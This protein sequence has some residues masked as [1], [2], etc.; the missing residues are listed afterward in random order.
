MKARSWISLGVL[1]SV[2]AAGAFWYARQPPVVTTVSAARGEAAEVVYANGVVEP[3]NW[4]RVTTLVRERLV[5][6]CDCEGESVVAGQVLA[7][8][9]DTEAQTALIELLERRRFAEDEFRRLNDLAARQTAGQTE[10]D[11][12]RTE[13]S[14]LE[15][16]VAGQRARLE[17]YVI[18]AP[19]DGVV[20]RRDAEVGEIAEPGAALFWVGQPRPLVVIADV[21]E[22]DIPRIT[23]GQR[24]LLRS[25]AFIELNLAAVVDNV[26]PKGDPVSKTYRVRLRLPDETPLM[27][28]M[29]V[30]VN[31]LIRVSSDTLLVPSLAVHDGRVFVVEDGLARRREVQ[32]GI[33]GLQSIEI[34]AGLADGD[35][36][37]TP[38][39]DQ[40]NDGVRVRIAG[41]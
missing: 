10:V 4:A 14:Q 15:A 3:R 12:A 21:N 31:V 16:L 9:N 25:D 29:S 38:F 33:R 34:L 18:R 6:E 39:P 19:I 35:R 1:V 40:L 24:A 23:V 13:L 41:E 17:H 28:G 32:P 30:D 7:R 22:E 2:S 11:R 20:L 26:T 8:L 36:V 5:E 37:I 27:I